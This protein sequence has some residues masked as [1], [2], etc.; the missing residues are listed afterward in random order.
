MDAITEG[1]YD[2]LSPSSA[3]RIYKVT[4]TVIKIAGI[5]VIQCHLRRVRISHT[6]NAHKVITPKVWFAQ[7]K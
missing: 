3:I 2:K 1:I 6:L 5:K 7:A 4:T